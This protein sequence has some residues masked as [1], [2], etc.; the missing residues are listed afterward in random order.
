MLN[1][2][3]DTRWLTG[4]FW[5]MNATGL[6][7]LCCKFG[8]WILTPA[9]FMGTPIVIKIST[10]NKSHIIL[11]TVNC[12][13]EWWWRSFLSM[14]RRLLEC[15]RVGWS[16]ISRHARKN[17]TIKFLVREREEKNGYPWLQIQSL[18][19]G[20]GLASKSQFGAGPTQLV[21]HWIHLCKWIH[22]YRYRLLKKTDYT[23]GPNFSPTNFM[24]IQ[25]KVCILLLMVKGR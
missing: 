10:V 12:A 25:P 5:A 14:M 22:A 3:L 1:N 19:A 18:V 21:S 8:L 23:I 4:I 24:P 20:R 6:D 13:T 17:P 11:N 7:P 2:A 15:K 9:G 16:K